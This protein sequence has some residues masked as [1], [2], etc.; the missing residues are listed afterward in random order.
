MILNTIL[1][2]DANVMGALACIRSL[3]RA[4][5]RIIATSE[6]PKAIGFY[7][8]YANVSLVQPPYNPASSFIKWLDHLIEQ[9]DIDCII[10]TEG[11]LLAIRPWIACYQCLIPIPQ[12][13]E[14]MYR[15]FSKFDFFSTF[16]VSHT[17]SKLGLQHLPP[18][19][20]ISS[21]TSTLEAL[22]D[23]KGPY[24]IKADAIYAKNESDS[25]VSK[26]F[27]LEDVAA[28]VPEYLQQYSHYIIQSHIKGQ[29][30]GVF[31]LRWQGS[32]I[33][34]F[35]HLRLHEVP[36]EGGVS[37]LR[38]SW[39]H[40]KIFQDAIGRVD[41]L[42]WNGVSMFEYRWD[43]STDEFFLIEMNARFWGSLHLP[44][45]AGVDF[46]K[47]LVSA[48]NN[49]SFSIPDAKIGVRCR[50]TFPLELEY[51][52]SRMRAS[53]LSVMGKFWTLLEFVLLSIDPRVKSDMMFP[54]DGWLYWWSISN[55][56]RKFLS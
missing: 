49:E 54:G 27:T 32:V 24:Y 56:V 50:L 33:A 52:I 9:H 3:G 13:Q 18:T 15:A 2:V 45:Y 43:S 22:K 8:R 17:N 29:G 34:H 39:W 55:T 12:S 14:E 19:A 20:L 7:S 42:N 35:M 11:L 41:Y 16:L 26:F 37:S 46:P 5:H 25:L 10:P 1:V 40:E 23:H 38:M 21:S 51:V 47:L 44:I 48:W 36:W 31:L 28:V 6:S 30:V 53:N 4:G